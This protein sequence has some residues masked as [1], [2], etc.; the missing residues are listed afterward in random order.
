MH[1][2]GCHAIPYFPYSEAVEAHR[3]RIEVKVSDLDHVV[4]KVRFRGSV[5]LG[6]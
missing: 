1:V 4:Q 2:H 3:S 5:W 6:I